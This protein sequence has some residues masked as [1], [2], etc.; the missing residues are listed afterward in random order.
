MGKVQIRRIMVGVLKVDSPQK[1]AAILGAS[2]PS[3]ALF[4]NEKMQSPGGVASAKIVP[5]NLR[6]TL[7]EHLA[8]MVCVSGAPEH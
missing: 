8:L 3:A 4:K 5:V 7:I 2:D 6:K 1:A